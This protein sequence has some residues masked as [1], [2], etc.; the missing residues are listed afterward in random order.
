MRTTLPLLALLPALACAPTVDEDG[1]TTDVA[2]AIAA[3]GHEFG[4]FEGETVYSLQLAVDGEGDDA[5]NLAALIQEGPDNFVTGTWDY[6]LGFQG[7]ETLTVEVG[8]LAFESTTLEK[9]FG[10]LVTFPAD[11]AE[12]RIRGFL[13]SP[14]SFAG[15]FVCEDDFW[16]TVTFTFGEDGSLAVRSVRDDDGNITDQDDYGAYFVEGGE[17]FLLRPE[18]EEPELRFLRGAPGDDAVDI[19]GRSCAAQGA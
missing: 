11:G 16:D 12:C 19:A 1:F 5:E 3:R 17:L 10:A 6:E 2:E 4:C 13:Q 14:G 15:A 8:D 9:K 7:E 18:R